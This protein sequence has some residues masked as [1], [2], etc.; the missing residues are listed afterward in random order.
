VD[1]TYVDNVVHALLLALDAPAE[2][3]IGKTYT[4]TN[5]ES[6]ALWDVIRLVLRRL[7]IDDGLRREPL[8]LVLAA[9]TLMEATATL[10]GREPRLT[11]YAALILAR[12]QTYNIEAA[13]RDLGYAPLV[14]VEEGL[15]R[16]LRA[17]EMK[18]AG[19][20][21][22]ALRRRTSPANHPGPVK[23]TTPL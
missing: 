15:E 23:P 3:V 5:G 21:A 10:T 19:G 13:R 4:I 2:R 12:T 14:T 20:V 11:R 6:V 22:P 7:G 18:A 8:P 9:A 17:F 1:L 16:T